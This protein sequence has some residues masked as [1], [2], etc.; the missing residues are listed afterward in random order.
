MAKCGSSEGDVVVSQLW[1]G[2]AESGED[3]GFVLRR[4]L[5]EVRGPVEQTFG[6][7]SL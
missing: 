1:L 6:E 5:C 7:L 4:C 3:D 2:L